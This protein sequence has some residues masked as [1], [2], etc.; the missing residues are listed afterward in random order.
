[1][2]NVDNTLHRPLRSRA[3]FIRIA[4]DQAVSINEVDDL[5]RLHV[6]VAGLDGAA[7]QSAIRRHALGRVDD[8][9]GIDLR[10]ATLRQRA[11]DRD[12]QWVTAFANM[13]GYARSKGW[14]TDGEH[15]RAH[16]V[17]IPAMPLESVA[18]GER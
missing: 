4:I 14:M 6:E 3:L 1:M 11:G 2:L 13:L 17:R 5:R 10:V 16:C 15:V 7:L 9:G 12:E 18:A 8:E